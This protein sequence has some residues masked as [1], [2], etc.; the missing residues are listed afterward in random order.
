MEFELLDGELYE[1]DEVK[2]ECLDKVKYCIEWHYE[3]YGEIIDFEECFEQ[4]DKEM[5][6]EK[7]M[8]DSTEVFFDSAWDMYETTV[9]TIEFYK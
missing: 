4:V 8:Y 1:F 7:W 5:E 9:E 3:N 6:K 2:A